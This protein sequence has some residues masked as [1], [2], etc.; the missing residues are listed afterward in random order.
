M[1]HNTGGIMKCPKKHVKDD[2]LQPF[3]NQIGK[4]GHFEKNENLIW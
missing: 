1:F 2:L 3:Q 4:M